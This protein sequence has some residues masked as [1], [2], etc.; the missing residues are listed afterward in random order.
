MDG[1]VSGGSIV[2]KIKSVKIDG[3]GIY[4]FNSALY[5]FESSTGFTLELDMI[6]TEVY[7]YWIKNGK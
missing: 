3:E 1:R 5:I 4:I 2:T 7:E 6:V